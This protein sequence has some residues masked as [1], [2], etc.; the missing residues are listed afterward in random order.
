MRLRKPPLLSQRKGDHQIFFLN[1]H[2]ATIDARAT[3]GEGGKVQAKLSPMKSYLAGWGLNEKDLEPLIDKIVANVRGHFADKALRTN[4]GYKVDFRNSKDDRDPW[5]QPNVARVIIGGSIDELGIKTIGIAQYVDPGNFVTTDT[6]VV[7][8]DS[9]SKPAP[10]ANSINSLPLAKGMSKIDAVARVVAAVTAHEIGHLLGCWHTRN[11]NSTICLMDQGGNLPNTAGVGP[12][13]I[14]DLNINV[15]RFLADEYADEGFVLP[16]HAENTHTR[17]AFALSTGT[18][19][20][21]AY[22]ASLERDLFQA[23]LLAV[24]EAR[25][26]ELEARRRGRSDSLFE[27]ASIFR[28]GGPE[29]PLSPSSEPLGGLPPPSYS[30]GGGRPNVGVL[31]PLGRRAPVTTEANADFWKKHAAALRERIRGLEQK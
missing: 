1:F 16:E 29:I 5:G 3:L 8:L 17:V 24:Q 21:K 10:N 12:G 20:A 14:L 11:D 6:A 30:Y 2:G 15:P 19:D 28:G 23:Q 9:L 26:T 18:L 7:L 25:R 13:G 27:L 4:P 22:R 31:F